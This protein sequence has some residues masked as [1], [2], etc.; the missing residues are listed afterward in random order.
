MFRSESIFRGCL[1]FFPYK[2]WYTRY[3]VTPINTLIALKQGDAEGAAPLLKHRAGLAHMIMFTFHVTSNVYMCIGRR[4]LTAATDDYYLERVIQSCIQEMTSETS[5]I[6]KNS[7]KNIFLF[8]LFSKT[9]RNHA[10][11]M[12]KKIIVYVCDMTKK[13]SMWSLRNKISSWNNNCPSE[14]DFLQLK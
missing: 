11:V 7:F 1:V 4:R 13:V 9:S 2:P 10:I 6:Y 12:S 3:S 5:Q 14:M 8:V